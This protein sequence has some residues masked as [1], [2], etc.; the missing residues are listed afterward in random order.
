MVVMQVHAP[1]GPAVAG[2]DAPVD[3]METDGA[4]FAEMLAETPGETKTPA[5][6]EEQ[7][8]AG[9]GDGTP[10]EIEPLKTGQVAADAAPDDEA[11]GTEAEDPDV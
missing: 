3:A 7:G 8:P 11:A 1:S 9:D 2:A 4:E 5:T 10:S 6:D